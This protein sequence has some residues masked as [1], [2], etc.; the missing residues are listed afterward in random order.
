MYREDKEPAPEPVPAIKPFSW[1]NPS[2]T[3]FEPPPPQ[4]P[5]PPIILRTEPFVSNDKEFVPVSRPLTGR[6]SE[7]GR[8]NNGYIS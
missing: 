7:S 3:P 4:S 6:V 8:G 5:K 1:L 2:G